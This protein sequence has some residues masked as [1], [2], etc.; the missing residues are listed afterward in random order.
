MVSAAAAV[1]WA[2]VNSLEYYW[3]GRALQ[4][5][6]TWVQVVLIALGLAFAVLTLRHVR[7]RVSDAMA[8]TL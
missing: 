1:L 8:E 6:D 7:R 4:G 2:A 3:F 5:A